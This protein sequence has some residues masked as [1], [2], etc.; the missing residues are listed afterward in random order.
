MLSLLAQKWKQGKESM[1]QIFQHF[2]LLLCT[3]SHSS[4]VAAS[5]IQFSYHYMGWLQFMDAKT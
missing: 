1:R 2:V 5:A 4:Y 3:I